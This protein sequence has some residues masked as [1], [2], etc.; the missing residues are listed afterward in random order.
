MDKK[1]RTVLG[2]I[3][4]KDL[5]FT[6]VHEHLWCSPPPQQ[7]DRDFELTK[8]DESLEE[9]KTFKKI[10]GVTLVD[11]SALDY[12]RDGNKLKQMAIES[13]VN[14]LGVTGFNKYIYYQDWVET[15]S[16]E[17]LMDRM[18][19]DIN[20]GMDGSDAKA[21]ILK[22]GSWYNLVHPLEEKTTR[23]IARV[24]LKTNAPI[25]VHTEA[26][27]MGLEMLDILEDE[28]VDLSNVAIGHSD[29]NAD[30]Y[31]HLQIVE[32]GAYIQFDGPS[33]VKYYPD[34]VRID[35]IKNILA[36][37]YGHKLLISGDMGRQSYLH[38]YGGGPGFRFIKEKFIPRMLD[39][40]ISQYAIDQIFYT[41]PA[42]WL[43]KF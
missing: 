31:Y 12:G 17:E 41:N 14:V 40:K 37:G 5:G 35:L 2:D 16:I 26:G 43:A 22:A 29:R 42:E 3:S 4:K 18:L 6:Y 34:N 8:Y 10:G 28:G 38:A 1:I 7:K 21:G 30:P 25:W 33:K 39:E 32:R 9:L 36:H 23:A 11:A 27:T 15:E 20:I 13:G 24:H 19:H